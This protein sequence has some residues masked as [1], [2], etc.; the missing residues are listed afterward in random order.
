MPSITF[1]K[2]SRSSYRDNP[3]PMILRVD[4]ECTVSPSSVSET[5]YFYFQ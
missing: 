2:D 1:W 5:A 3:R 4:S